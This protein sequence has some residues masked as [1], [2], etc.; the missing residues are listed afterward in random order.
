[1]EKREACGPAW[2]EITPATY[3]LSSA[4]V[5]ISFF[6]MRIGVKVIIF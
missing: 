4:Y 3:N 1:M 6:K 2:A 5:P